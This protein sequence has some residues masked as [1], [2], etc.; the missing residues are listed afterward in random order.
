MRAPCR[1]WP[2]RGSLAS[3]L[4]SHVK[5]SRRAIANMTSQMRRERPTPAVS[6][7]RASSRKWRH[8]LVREE[9]HH[10]ERLFVAPAVHP[11][12]DD[13]GLQLLGEGPELVAHGCRA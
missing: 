12:A 5:N 13:A 8:H 4:R 3:R 2:P 10:V 1:G 6:S 9:L 11:R 7:T